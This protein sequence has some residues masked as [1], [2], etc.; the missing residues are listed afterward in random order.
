MVNE[1]GIFFLILLV[2]EGKIIRS[3]LVL[4]CL[5]TA[6]TIE[7]LFFCDNGFSFRDIDIEELNDKSEN[8][9]TNN[10]TENWK[11]VFKKSEM[12]SEWKKLQA[13]LEE[14]ESDI[15]DPNT[16]AVLCIRKLSNFALYVINK[17]S[18]IAFVI[19][20]CQLKE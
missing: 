8:E 18:N 2:K 17:F 15:L 13:N 19:Q 5:A 12:K 10:S 9:I 20:M 11:N 4:G 3:W 14:Y 16:I 7:K 1:E 6:H